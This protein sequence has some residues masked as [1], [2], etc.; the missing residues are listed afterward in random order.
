MTVTVGNKPESKLGIGLNTRLDCTQQVINFL[1]GENLGDHFR[2]GDTHV[3]RPNK[4]AETPP[5]N[6][7]VH[8]FYKSSVRSVSLSG[9][10]G[11]QILSFPLLPHPAVILSHVII[12][13][14]A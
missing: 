9:V 13:R 1:K 14:E 11:T 7:A 5:T 2:T 6:E 12:I 4:T 10:H 8:G 3:I